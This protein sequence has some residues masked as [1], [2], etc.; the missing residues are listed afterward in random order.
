MVLD[1]QHRGNQNGGRFGAVCDFVIARFAHAK[2]WV[3]AKKVVAE[4]DRPGL[5][6]KVFEPVVRAVGNMAFCGQHESLVFARAIGVAGRGL[7]E[8]HLA[9]KKDGRYWADKGK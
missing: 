4:R 5:V 2:N 3:A 9:E 7:R 8:H 1:F 6:E